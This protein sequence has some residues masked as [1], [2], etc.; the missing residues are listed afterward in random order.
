MNEFDREVT[1][2][3]RIAMGRLQERNVK[4]WEPETALF[5]RIEVRRFVANLTDEWI[6]HHVPCFRPKS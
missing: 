5:A 6:K 2:Q 1:R 4:P 3:A